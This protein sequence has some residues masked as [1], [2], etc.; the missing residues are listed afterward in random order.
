MYPGV[1]T[2][3]IH[4][5]VYTHHGT[6]LHIHRGAYIHSDTYPGK[7]IYTGIPTQGGYNPPLDT[8]QGGYNPSFRHSSGTPECVTVS[9]LMY[10][11]C[12]AS[13]R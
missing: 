3:H 6:T 9:P 2:L 11:G 10:P 1:Y 7:H 12:V 5:E 13:S 4:R 8:P